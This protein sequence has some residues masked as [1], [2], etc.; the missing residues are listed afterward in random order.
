MTSLT[1]TWT[2]HD[3]GWAT[4]VVAD[5]TAEAEA[6]VSYVTEGP[7]QFLSA[8]ARAV[9]GATES[10]A[11]FEAEPT[12]YRWIFQRIQAHVDIR[13]LVLSRR[14]LPDESG[15]VIWTSRQPIQ[16]LARAVIRAFD[17]VLTEHGEDGYQANWGRPFPTLELNALRTAWRTHVDHP[18]NPPKQQN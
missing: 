11:E 13:L 5:Q 15:D 4:C 6:L 16:V 3:H 18:T 9:L 7:E 14:E 2:V 8:V 1:L 17:A 12:A 10:R